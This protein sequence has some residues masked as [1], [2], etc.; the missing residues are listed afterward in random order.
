VFVSIKEK[1]TEIKGYVTTAFAQG[2]SAEGLPVVLMVVAVAL[3]SYGLGY[4]SAEKTAVLPPPLPLMI[5]DQAPFEGVVSN[6]S[7]TRASTTREVATPQAP[8]RASVKNSAP[9]ANTEGMYVG[10]RK[11]T[12]YHLPWCAGARTISEENRV[13]FASKEE[14]ETQGYAPAK[15]CK[16]I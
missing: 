11:G 14:A 13:W 6:E 5:H 3:A 4:K 12:K 1:A 9:E 10:S 16:G 8:E 15:N 2:G 7:T